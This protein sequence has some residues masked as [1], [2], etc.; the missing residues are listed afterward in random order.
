MI[1]QAAL[2][3]CQD[4]D[5]TLLRE[6]AEADN[7]E[8]EAWV[9]KAALDRAEPLVVGWPTVEVDGVRAPLWWRILPPFLRPAR[10]ESVGV[11]PLRIL[12]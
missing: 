5:L 8:L 11:D 4:S 7:L 6:T 9:R 1:G 10:A 3:E 12:R 2:I